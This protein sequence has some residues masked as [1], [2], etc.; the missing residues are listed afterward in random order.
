MEITVATWKVEARRIA[1]F[2]VSPA[3]LARLG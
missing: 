2:Q 3:K 1:G